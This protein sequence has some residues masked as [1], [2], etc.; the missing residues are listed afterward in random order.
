MKK[1]GHIDINAFFAQAEVLRH[2]ELKGKPI[3]VGNDGRRGVIATASYEARAFGVHSAMPS[4]Q[5]FRL[6][7]DLVMLEGDFRYYELLSHNLMGYL[8]KRLGPLEQASIDEAFV[9]LTPFLEGKKDYEALF[10]LQLAIFK[11]TEL[12]VSI[13][14]GD[15]K[16][17]AKM[18]SDYKKPL[19]VTIINSTNLATIL[20]PLAIDKMY[21]IG[22]KTAPRLEELGI[23]TIGDLAH[24]QNPEVKD[25]L[26]NLFDYFQGE[27]NGFGDDTIDSSAFDPKSISAE[28]TFSEDVSSYE[29]LA[30]MIASCVRDIADEL[31]RYEKQSDVVSIKLRSPDFVTKS[32]QRHLPFP[33]SSEKDVRQAALNL[34]DDIYRNEPIRLIGVGLEK[35]TDREKAKE[36]SPQEK[37]DLSRLNQQLTL[38]GK[39]FL[40]KDLKEKKKHDG[41]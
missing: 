7:P 38:G 11:A 35:V 5:A 12:K 3:A 8:R 10:D 24:T 17:L 21:G 40:G 19:G 1:I 33:V 37:E 32:R 23:H 25:L 26:G 41:D 14:L 39:I 6:C 2:P 16:F 31:D 4:S 9:D 29:E 13:G 20:W 30:S 22:K 28:R 36:T 15:N 34:F 18:A 27:A